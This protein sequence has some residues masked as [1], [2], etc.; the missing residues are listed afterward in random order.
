[1]KLKLINPI[2]LRGKYVKWL[3]ATEYVCVSIPFMLHANR[4]SKRWCCFIWIR[5][6]RFTFCRNCTG[7]CMIWPVCLFIYIGSAGYSCLVG[8]WP[9][10]YMMHVNIFCF[11]STK[12]Q[13]RNT[14]SKIKNQKLMIARWKPMNKSVWGKNGWIGV[15]EFSSGGFFVLLLRGRCLYFLLQY[16]RRCKN[17]PKKI[18]ENFDSV[19]GTSFQKYLHLFSISSIICVVLL[20]FGFIF[21]SIRSISCLQ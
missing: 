17:K 14:K 6:I 5:V 3:P 2:T 19:L 18:S 13:K 8:E 15:T 9:C 10:L 7:Y 16:G 21:R 4:W 11:F 20:I 12:Q 1:M